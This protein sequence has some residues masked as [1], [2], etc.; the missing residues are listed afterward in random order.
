MAVATVG[1]AVAVVLINFPVLPL[2]AIRVMA[3]V[4]IPCQTRQAQE[5]VAT[6]ITLCLL[7]PATL[8]MAAVAVI[9]QCQQPRAQLIIAVEIIEWALL[10]QHII[11]A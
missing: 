11:E 9:T 1:M 3:A 6:V 5:E 4:I 8:D 2:P 7:P 10:P